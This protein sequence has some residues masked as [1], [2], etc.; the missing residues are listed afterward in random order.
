MRVYMSRTGTVQGILR[1]WEVWVEG[2]EVWSYGVP[3]V[4]LQRP[5]S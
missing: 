3:D 1:W 2:A 4:K 5:G